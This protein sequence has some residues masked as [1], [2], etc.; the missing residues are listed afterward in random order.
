MSVQIS[1][2]EA[3]GGGGG[4]GSG[5]WGGEFTTSLV[6]SE[7]PAGILKI[8]LSNPLT[9][10]A[11]QTWVG[12]WQPDAPRTDW[13][14]PTAA[15]YPVCVTASSFENL[16][17]LPAGLAGR[18]LLTELNPEFNIIIVNMDGSQRQV[19]VPQGGQGSLSLDGSR[20]AYPGTDG[21]T[22]LNISSGESSLL[23]GASGYDLHWSP[24]GQQIAYVNKGDAY[25][26]FVTSTDGSSQRQLSTLGYESIAGWSPDGKQLYYAI[27]DS[28]GEGWL[29]K[30][31]EVET[32]AARD[33]FVLKYS[34]RKAPFP[35]VSPDGNWI[36]YRGVDN[37]SLYMMRMDGTQRRLLIE[38]PSLAYAISGIAWGP[39]GDLL[40]VSMLTPDAPDGSVI[41][42]KWETFET[43]ILPSLHGELDGLLIP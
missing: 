28:S 14:A 26:I 27:P 30:S 12:E 11:T 5:A 37:G 2:Y 9:A 8:I 29:L 4:G 20:M 16:S 32:G 3:N 19:L 10:S 13:P 34:S 40:G 41:L 21:I 42:M 18:A 36:A 15:A 39:G 1:G 6:Y 31:V 43:Y 22:I 33:L 17:P 7:L 25:G 35:V 23:Q 38:K 24:D